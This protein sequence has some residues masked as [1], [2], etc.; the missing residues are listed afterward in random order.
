VSSG[1]AEE[2]LAQAASLRLLGLLLERPRGGWLEEVESLA[3]EVQDPELKSVA[4]EARQAREGTYLR[5]FG[6]GGEISPRE[7]AY[8]SSEDPGQILADL[9]GFYQ[10]FAFSPRREDPPDHISV[11]VGFLGYLRL[12]EAYA[13]ARGAKQEASLAGEAAR[14]FIEDHLGP[15]A[16]ALAKRLESSQVAYLARCA[17]V[18]SR[19]AKAS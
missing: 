1:S 17:S 11:E 4:R 18:L 12:K 19:I 2:A 7:V 8:R 13:M 6:P 9:E 15:F 5:L 10:A 16:Q 3:R 14:R